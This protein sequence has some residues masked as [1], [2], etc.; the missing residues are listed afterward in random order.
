MGTKKQLSKLKKVD[1]RDVFAHEASG[2]SNWLIQKENI[3][4]LSD[5]ISIDIIPIS[6]EASVG[7]FRVDILAE[8]ETSQR[9]IIIE[10]QL[11]FSDHDHLGKII[12]YASGHD[13]QI[14]IWIVKEVRDEHRKAIEWLNEHTEES[15]GFF[16]IQFELWQIEKS[17]PAPK[18]EVIVS[19]NEWVKSIKTSSSNRELTTAGL[20]LLDFWEKFRNYA[21]KKD[22]N[23]RLRKPFSQNFYD[24]AIGFSGT[25][26]VL[27]ATP[28]KNTIACGLW[29]H[30]DKDLY[31]FL[32]KKKDELEKEIGESIE[33]GD[34]AIT[35]VLKIKKEVKSIYDP[36]DIKINHE[37]L[38]QSYKIFKK[39]LPRYINEF[40][41]IK[42]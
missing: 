35:S 36:A 21:R 22:T 5:A 41:G 30:K 32:F 3:E 11:E 25:H 37:W 42:R 39:V 27:F 4:L 9:K 7:K 33:W 26:V 14:I 31:R 1:L 19:P 6:T 10:N 8:E 16:L 23:M 12:T 24:I 29:I 13:A 40:R 15:I 28:H 17:D 2:F 34:N 18:F 38:Y 20:Q